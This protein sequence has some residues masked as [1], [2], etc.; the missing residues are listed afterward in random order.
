MVRKTRF[1]GFYKKKERLVEAHTSTS[2]YQHQK[3]STGVFRSP[4]PQPQP[5]AIGRKRGQNPLQN[6]KQRCEST[7]PQIPQGAP[8]VI[9]KALHCIMLQSAAKS[10]AWGAWGK[11]ESTI[12]HR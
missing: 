3:K 6:K 11:K 12:P 8:R 7:F 1:R 2:I 10:G 5:L 9:W 4:E